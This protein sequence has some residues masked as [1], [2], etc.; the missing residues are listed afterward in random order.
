MLIESIENENTNL[1]KNKDYDKR[2]LGIIM[3]YYDWD[4]RS[5]L[6]EISTNYK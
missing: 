4:F 5:N 3:D 6:G 2:G 1:L